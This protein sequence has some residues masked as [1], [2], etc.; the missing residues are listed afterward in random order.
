[1][2]A[3]SLQEDGFGVG[4]LSASEEYGGELAVRQCEAML[5]SWQVKVAH[6]IGPSY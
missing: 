1:M 5:V 6:I 3:L 4:T 2:E